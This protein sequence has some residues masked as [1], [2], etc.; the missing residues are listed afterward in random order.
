[1]PFA[2]ST[3]LTKRCLMLGSRKCKHAEQVSKVEDLRCFE[4]KKVLNEERQ[5]LSKVAFKL[6]AV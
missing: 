5:A 3:Q 2:T 6:L 1:M 4:D